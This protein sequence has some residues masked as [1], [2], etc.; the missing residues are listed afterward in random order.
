LLHFLGR[1]HGEK[2]QPIFN[3]GSN[4]V[5]QRQPKRGRGTAVFEHTAGFVKAVDNSAISYQLSAISYEQAPAS[6]SAI[7]YQCICV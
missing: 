6:Q 5:H 2:V 3:D 7:S 1:F 4:A